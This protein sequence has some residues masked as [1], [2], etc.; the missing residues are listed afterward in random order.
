MQRELG[1]LVIAGVLRRRQDGNRT[2]YSAQTES[3]IYADLSGLFLKTAGLRDVLAA[4]LEPFRD[5]IN[6]AF[7]YGSIARH[8]EGPTSDIDLMII[9][10]IGLAQLAAALKNAE[11]KLSRPVNPSIY[12]PEEIAEKLSLGHHFLGTVMSKEKLFVVGDEDDLA[13]A[14]QLKSRPTPRNQQAGTR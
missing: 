8:E 5:R 4:C 10:R 7:V 3:P 9:G 11:E 12:T 1:R 2:Y 6:V 14:T 13:A